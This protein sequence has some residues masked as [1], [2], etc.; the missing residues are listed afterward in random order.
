MAYDSI[1][2]GLTFAERVNHFIQKR[3]SY[4]STGFWTLPSADV[5]FLSHPLGSKRRDDTSGTICFTRDV[6]LSKD[7]G[8]PGT[9]A[10]KRKL[11]KNVN[12]VS[13]NPRRAKA[14]KIVRLDTMLESL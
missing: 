6:T 7:S 4:E 12:D 10:A 8:H 13:M 1:K 5:S 9:E 2:F 11:G 3:R 14:T